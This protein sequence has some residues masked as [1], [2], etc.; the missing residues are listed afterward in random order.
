MRVVFSNQYDPPSSSLGT[1]QLAHCFHEVGEVC[2]GLLLFYYAKRHHEAL[3]HGQASYLRGIER[4]Q[5]KKVKSKAY[6]GSPK[7]CET[8]TKTGI[9]MKHFKGKFMKQVMKK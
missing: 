9:M 3:L 6:G 4:T 1:L 5:Q 7:Q 8:N 2:V